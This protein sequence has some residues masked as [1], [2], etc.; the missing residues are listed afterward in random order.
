M[1]KYAQAVAEDERFKGTETRWVFWALS[2]K[3]TAGAKREASA[4]DRAPGLV[5]I[6]EDPNIEIWTKEWGQVIEEARARLSFFQ[7]NLEYTARRDDAVQYLRRTH[8]KYLPAAVAA[9]ARP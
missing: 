7:E 4:P 3:I 8:E 2:N 6:Y 5:Q 1:K 9:L